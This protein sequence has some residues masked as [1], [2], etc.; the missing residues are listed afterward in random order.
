[1]N[2]KEQNGLQT[3]REVEQQHASSKHHRQQMHARSAVFLERDIVGSASCRQ[4]H[5]KHVRT[6]KKGM[7]NEVE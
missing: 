1:L 5:F 4:R 6:V 7:Q 3:L 2:K